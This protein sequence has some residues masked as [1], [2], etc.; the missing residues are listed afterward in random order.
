MQFLEI[1]EN[2]TLSELSQAVGSR[3]VDEVLTANGLTRTPDIGKQF[4]QNCDKIK[5]ES[6]GT[7]STNRKMNLLNTLTSDSEVYEKA[8]LMSE[9]E[10]QVFASLNTFDNAL[11]IPSSVYMPSSASLIGSNQSISSSV[12]Q[13]TMREL[14]N[15]GSI[16]PAI[17]SDYASGSLGSASV[18][19]GTVNSPADVFS[20]FHIPWGEVQLYSS[21][22]DET[23]DFPVYPEEVDY[24]RVANY[25]T[26][27]ETLFQYE[28]WYI[29]ES[30]GPREQSIVFNFHRDMWTGDH[31]DGKANELIRFCEANCYAEYNGASVIT[32]TVTLYIHGTAFITGVMKQ[33][34]PHWTGPIG[35]DGWY[36]HCELTITIDEVA[37]AP[38]SY[39]SIRKMNIIG[40]YNE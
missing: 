13:Q 22:A 3:N 29:Y 12:Y 25:T 35:R 4:K 17:F 23:I 9:S 7:I 15:N 34:Q 20:A 6:T 39:S 31:T 24:T 19:L 5:R 27:N 21:L 40:G 8:C 18:S 33:V 11:K 16:N 37:A 36:L 28:P 14:K 2:T 38:L 32:P 30:S 10:W 26:M 1:N